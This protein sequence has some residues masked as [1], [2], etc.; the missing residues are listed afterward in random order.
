MRE[1][2][3]VRKI[4]LSKYL[5]TEITIYAQ[6]I[7][8]MMMLLKFNFYMRV[9]KNFSLMIMLVRDCVISILPFTVYLNLWLIT[10]QY[11]YAILGCTVTSYPG[12]N[13]FFGFYLEIWSNSIGNINP[14]ELPET[15]SNVGR[16]YCIYLVWWFNQFIILI[17]LLNFLI[18]IIG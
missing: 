3:E 11:L 16:T 13:N 17:V 7:I 8:V 4:Q 18:A 15:G 5:E 6:C 14:P 2:H 12:I 10:I 9:F 1:Y